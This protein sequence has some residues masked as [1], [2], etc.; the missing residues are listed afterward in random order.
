MN[1]TPTCPR[2]HAA[3]YDALLCPRCTQRIRADL[4]R[5]PDI[6]T[7]LQDTITGQVRM[8]DGGRTNEPP[9]P[10]RE[11]AVNAS[12]YVHNQLSTWIRDLDCGDID[13]GDNVPA[14]SAWLQQRVERI[15]S[16]PAADEAADEFAYCVTIMLPLVDRPAEMQ[17]CGKCDT[18][19]ADLYAKPGAREATCRRCQTGGVTTTYSPEQRRAVVLAQLEHHWGT[20]TECSRILLNYG[21]DVETRTIKDWTRPNRHGVVKLAKRGTNQAGHSLYRFG[22]VMTLAQERRVRE[23]SRLRDTG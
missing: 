22:D 17:F 10:Y 7:D 21:L 8:S 2:C 4:T 20:V 11:K 5:I 13:C 9:L 1:D 14:M 16:H 18:C 6:W 15:R 12:R 19:N 23:H 3:Q